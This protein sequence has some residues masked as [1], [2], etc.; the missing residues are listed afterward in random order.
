MVL[1][2][3]CG[4]VDRSLRYKLTVEET[5]LCSWSARRGQL[6]LLLLYLDWRIPRLAA[7]EPAFGTAAGGS[8][9]GR[10]LYTAAEL[11][12]GDK[13][14]TSGCIWNNSKH[15]FSCLTD[16]KFVLLVL[17]TQRKDKIQIKPKK[18]TVFSI[19]FQALGAG[20]KEMV[21]LGV[22]RQRPC[23]GSLCVT[24]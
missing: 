2:W 10:W 3:E 16:R 4:T 6:C 8:W 1:G 24:C 18:K 22:E 15:N 5:S 11:R 19:Y 17:W 13:S 7:A 12:S 21:P 20:V 9:Q 23:W 14:R